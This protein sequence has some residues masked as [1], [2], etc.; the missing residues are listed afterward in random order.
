MSKFRYWKMFLKRAGFKY[1]RNFIL[2]VFVINFAIMRGCDT[3]YRIKYVENG[4]TKCSCTNRYPEHVDG[5]S[6]QTYMIG[7]R[8]VTIERTLTVF[9][10]PRLLNPIYI[11]HTFSK[12]VLD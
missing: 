11:W 5:F 9:T 3:T 12:Y 6:E 1:F 8:R 7:E 10:Y 4:R 2:I